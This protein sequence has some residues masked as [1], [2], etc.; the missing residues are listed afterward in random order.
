MP[1]ILTDTIHFFTQGMY[2]PDQYYDLVTDMF[3]TVCDE[4]DVDKSLLDY[5]L[6]HIV[7][8]E[9]ASLSRHPSGRYTSDEWLELDF[10]SRKDAEWKKANEIVGKINTY[11][12]R[13]GIIPPLRPYAVCDKQIDIKADNITITANPLAA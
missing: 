7:V 11:S 1:K 3:A 6:D 13:V 2:T 9:D 5:V 12:K 10:G 4:E 8:N